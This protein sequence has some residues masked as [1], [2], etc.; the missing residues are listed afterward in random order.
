MELIFDIKLFQPS[1]KSFHSMQTSFNFKRSDGLIFG[2]YAGS[3]VGSNPEHDI[4]KGLPDVPQHTMQALMDLHKNEIPFLVR[5]YII[6]AGSGKTQ[7]VTPVNMAQYVTKNC[8]LDIAICYRPA[9]Y[10]KADWILY[11]HSIIH[12]Y[13]DHLAKIQ[14]TEEPNNPD[15][16][17][18]GDGSS[19]NIKQAIIDG[20][21]AAKESI[22][23]LGLDIQ[24]GFNAVISFNPQDTFFK[25]IASF[26]NS[27]FI[28][29]LDYVGLD[30]YPGVFRPLPPEMSLKDAV[31]AVLTHFRNNNLAAAQIPET[32]PIHITE[33]GFPTNETRSEAEQTKAIEEII[34]I[35][36]EKR[37]EL[38]ITHYAFFDLRDADQAL[39][40][41]HFGLLRA[42]YSAKPAFKAFQNLIRK[43]N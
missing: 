40:G 4:V 43:Y 25:D 35:I 6:Y 42:D 37:T 26:S 13:K 36:Y 12:Q 17:S 24:V 41:F 31:I 2:I 3:G 19:P 33:N 27:D 18:G 39:L 8:K 23:K 28:N 32:I 16:A 10:D 22:I 15:A 11:I 20:V 7:N 34:T 21:I 5:G 38:N 1:T 14:I 9:I 29:A 30:F